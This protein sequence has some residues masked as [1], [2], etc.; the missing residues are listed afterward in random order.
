MSRINSGT[1]SQ[2]ASLIQISMLFQSSFNAS[3][4]EFVNISPWVGD[5]MI[6]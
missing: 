3:D 2:L 5:L 1:V 6:F 4:G